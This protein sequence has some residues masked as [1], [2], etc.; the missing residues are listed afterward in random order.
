MRYFKIQMFNAYGV[1]KDMVIE[2]KT[3]AKAKEK[4]NRLFGVYW[5]MASIKE[6]TKGE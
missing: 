4:W 6:V 1:Y 2:G 3:R 5:T